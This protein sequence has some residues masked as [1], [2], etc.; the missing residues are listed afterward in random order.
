[1][2]TSRAEQKRLESL[3]PFEL[4]DELIKLA[5]ENDRENAIAMLNAGRG[6]PNWIATEPRDAFWLLGR[7]GIAESKLDWDEWEGVGGMPQKSGIAARFAKFLE[8]NRKEPG[9]DLLQRSLDYGVAKLDF[10]AD[11]FVWEL[12]DRKSVV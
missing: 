2:K 8:K 11:A 5:D 10:D 6:N 3:S 7:F 1:M 4:K 12:A 9:A